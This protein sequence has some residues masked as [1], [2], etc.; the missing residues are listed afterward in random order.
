MEVWPP[1]SYDAGVSVMNWVI[2]ELYTTYPDIE[3]QVLICDRL[4]VETDRR[5]RSDNFANL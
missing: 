4:D 3:I 1:R 2:V 5:Y